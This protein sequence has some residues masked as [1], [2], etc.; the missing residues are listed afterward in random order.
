MSF[1]GSLEGA[2]YWE[3]IYIIFLFAVMFTK[4]ILSG[5]RLS[6]QKL[7]WL[8]IK[9]AEVNLCE[10]NEG[11]PEEILKTVPKTPYRSRPITTP[12]LNQPA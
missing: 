3:P 10:M 5:K 11:Q 12:M 7:S 9:I 4:T 1:S 6:T 8:V 2:E